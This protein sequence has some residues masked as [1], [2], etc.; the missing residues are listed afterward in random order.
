MTLLGRKNVDR[1]DKAA[2][3]QI[4]FSRLANIMGVA[5]STGKLS[6]IDDNLLEAM[7]NISWHWRGILTNWKETHD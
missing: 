4:N 1:E 6:E 7:Y 2:Q 5:H 3:A